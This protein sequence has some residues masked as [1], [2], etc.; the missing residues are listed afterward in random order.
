MLRD[1]ENT[2]A[3][4]PNS[5]GLLQHAGFRQFI[6][7]CIV[8]ASSTLISLSIFSALIYGLQ[9]SDVLYD[10][11]A[12]RPQW[13]RIAA[14]YRL[15]VQVAALIAFLFSVTN[16]FFWN[17]R[18]TFRQND[19]AR[20]KSQ[21]AKFVLVNAIGL[22]LNQIILF[23]VNRALTAGRAANEKGWEP[24]IAFAI[25]TSIVVFWNFTANKLWTFKETD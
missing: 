4:M 3:S 8:G 6:K 20:R 13:Q 12:T 18:W 11:L 5:P 16:G 1:M 15:H 10:A 2:P 19:P 14:E 23:V 21:Y 24:L 22:V 7:F 25:A 9:L 17:S